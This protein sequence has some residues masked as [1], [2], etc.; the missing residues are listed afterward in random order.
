MSVGC[1]PCTLKC[2]TNVSS[3]LGLGGRGSR[4]RL[5][6]HTHGGGTECAEAKALGPSTPGYQEAAAMGIY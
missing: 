1:A 6:L 4:L 3:V 5:G 2:S